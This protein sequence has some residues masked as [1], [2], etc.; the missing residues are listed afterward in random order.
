MEVLVGSARLKVDPSRLRRTGEQETGRE[1][2]S[3]ITLAQPASGV[4]LS[5]EVNLRGLRV[6]E[7]LERL[8]AYLDSALASGLSQVRIVHGKGTGA[9]AQR[10]MAAPRRQPLYRHL[11]PGTQGARRRRRDRGSAGLSNAEYVLGGK[12]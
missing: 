9:A 7:A 5:G 3:S 4:G 8:D 1:G 12:Q 6:D 2:R 11:Q 10:R